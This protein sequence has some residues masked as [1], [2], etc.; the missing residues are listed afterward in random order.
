[1]KASIK[2]TCAA[3]LLTPTLAFG[4]D[5][6]PEVE[7]A[8]TYSLPETNC[9]QPV[10]PGVSKDVIDPATGAVNRADIDSYQLGRFER[11]ETRWMKCLT[12]YKKGLMEDFGA[13][14]DSARHGLT[15][16]QA[17]QILS[18]MADIQA[19]IES[20]DGIPKNAEDS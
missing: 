20:P 14:R 18:N 8:I 5:V 1:M 2:A 3:L 7:K 15:E 9:E 16:D 4:A 11:A 13:L 10:L 12:K 17:K 19:A 6:H